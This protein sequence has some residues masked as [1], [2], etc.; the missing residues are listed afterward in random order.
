MRGKTSIV[1][2]PSIK[3]AIH[4]HPAGVVVLRRDRQGY[5]RL[6]QKS[7]GTWGSPS[8]PCSRLDRDAFKSGI[9]GGENEV[10]VRRF[11]AAD[12]NMLCFGCK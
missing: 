8:H 11:C 4:R 10:D 6:G 1:E 7:R 2:N 5:Y 9:G 3:L 12:R